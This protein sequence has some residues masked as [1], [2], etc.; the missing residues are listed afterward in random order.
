MLQCTA[1]VEV[2]DG[3]Q[4]AHGSCQCAIVKRADGGDDC[5]EIL[6]VRTEFNGQSRGEERLTA[7]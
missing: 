7:L 2:G 6:Q 4:K 3:G 1:D 5:A